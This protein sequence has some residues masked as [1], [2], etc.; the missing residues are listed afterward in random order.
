MNEAQIFDFFDVVTVMSLFIGLRNMGLNQT[1]LSAKSSQN[2]L[3]NKILEQQE[4][5][6]DRLKELQH[7]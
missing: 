6:L 5:I 7:D 3:L 4:E 2:L 1:Q